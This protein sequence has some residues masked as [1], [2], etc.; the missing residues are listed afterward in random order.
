LEPIDEFED[1]L[2]CLEG[3]M[4]HVDE[5]VWELRNNT[6]EWKWDAACQ[7]MGPDVFY[8]EH[9]EKAENMMKIVAARE[10]CGR[11]PV[12]VECLR[13]A[14]DNC[15]G[16]GIWAGTTPNQRKRL[17]HGRTGQI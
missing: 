5:F 17:R 8:M 15:I 1:D 6:T 4:G 16:T 13:Y 2:E 3:N 14:V 7:G 9:G 10:I 12:K 11:C